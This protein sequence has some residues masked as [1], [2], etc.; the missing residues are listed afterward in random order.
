M[1]PLSGLVV[2]AELELELTLDAELSALLGALVDAAVVSALDVVVVDRLAEV[3]ELAPLKWFVASRP[4]S[5]WG[6]PSLPWASGLAWLAATLPPH[7]TSV[8]P[9]PTRG[10]DERILARTIRSV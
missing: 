6:G 8:T 3:L 2:V 5:R 9:R 4:A 1:N 7:P 10:R